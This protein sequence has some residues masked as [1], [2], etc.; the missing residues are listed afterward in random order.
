MPFVPITLP[1]GVNKTDS[2]Y[3]ATGRWIDTDKVRFVLG[4]PEKIGG[5]RK[6]TDETF[7][8]IA[9]GANAWAMFNGTQCLAFGTQYDL[10]VYRGGTINTITPYRPDANPVSL[11]NPFTTTNG[12]A[13]V[14]VADTNHGI[15]DVGVTVTFDGASAVGGITIDGDYLVASIPNANSYTIVHSSPASSGATGGGSVSAYYEI[16]FGLDTPAYQFGWGVGGWGEG[17]WGVTNTVSSEVISEPRWW[18]ISTYGEDTILNPSNGTIY[19]SDSSLGILRPQP[20]LNAPAQVRSSFVTSERFIFA[21]GCTN[22]NGDFDAMC[23]RWPDVEDFTDWDVTDINT[24]NERKLQGGSRL[25]AGAPLT[26]GVALVWSDY[27]VFTFQYTGSGF[28]YNSRQVGTE[29]GLIGPHAFC[30]TDMMAIWM[31]AN[32]F[33]IYSSYVQPVPN[34][35]NILDWVTERIN[36][37]NMFK[38]ISFYHKDQDEAWFIFPTGTEE[39]DTYAAVNLSNY[40]WITGT[41]GDSLS[42]SAVA[43][44][45]TNETRPIM[46]GLEGNIF[47]HEVVENKDNDG[48]IMEAYATFA[49]FALQEGNTSVDVFGLVPD[50][51]RQRGDVTFELYGKDHPQDTVMEEDTVTA[52]EGDVLVDVHLAGRQIGGTIRSNAVGGDFRL[53]RWGMEISGAGTKRGSK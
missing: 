18:S 23:V 50:F 46:F 45:T 51:K 27:S 10:Y 33:H 44:Y 42:R 5:I 32:G 37:E 43:K 9:R 20:I 24:A 2:D 7:E 16:N 39:P 14:T 22:L 28:I 13:V 15:A 11:T 4:L 53:G 40:E 35:E 48:Q 8:G 25:I 34:Q 47:I 1:P 17:A 19:Y 49:P 21:L 30:K 29:C 36:T 6:L 31:S 3:Q 12:S 26:S 52:A 41:M 38:T